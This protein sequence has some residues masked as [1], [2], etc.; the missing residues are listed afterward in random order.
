MNHKHTQGIRPRSN[1]ASGNGES[2]VTPVYLDH[3]AT[4]PVRQEVVEAMTP[5]FTEA[6]GNA[7]SVHAL[8]KNARKALENARQE[9]AKAI[10]AAP[11]EIYF[12]SGGTESDNTAVKGVMRAKRSKGGHFIT[13]AIEHMAGLNSGKALEKEGFQV[14][15]LPVD[16]Y[17]I[18]E[19]DALE[20]AISDETALISVMLA[21]NETGVI[22]PLRQIAEIAKKHDIPVHTDAVQALGKIPVNVDDLGVDLLSVSGHKIYGPKGIGVLYV[23]KGTRFAPLL[24]G[25]HHERNKRP[26]TENVPAIV[27]LGKAVELAMGEME[28]TSAR[29]KDLRDRLEQ[30]IRDNVEDVYLNGHHEKRLPNVLNMSFEFV[31][32]ESLLLT[33]DHKGVA[34]STGSACTSGSLEPSHVLKAMG[35]DPA[36][37][38]GSL[39]FSLGRDNTAEQMDYV[40]ECLGEVVGRLRQMSPL[41]AEHYAEQQKG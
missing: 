35:M 28:E 21:N 20:E 11:E 6:Y 41:Y 17:G 24:H 14:T 40:V 10:G 1:Q 37:S 32:G 7:S 2:G 38:H 27:G 5:F 22:Q 33:L 36:L 4:T 31:E 15:Y 25:G 9:V 39:R 13:S 34:V 30:G 8:G 18:V 16:E 3:S 29:L 12:T 23:R 19:L 26:G